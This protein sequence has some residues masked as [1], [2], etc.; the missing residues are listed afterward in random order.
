MVEVPCDDSS[1]MELCGES[2]AAISSLLD[3]D[4]LTEEEKNA[5]ILT[6]ADKQH[7]SPRLPY[8]FTIGGDRSKKKFSI[9]SR[10]ASNDAFAASRA[11]LPIYEYRANILD[12]INANQVVVISGETGSGKTTQVP[13]Y[14][15][16]Q[17][18]EE[19]K[20]C[21]I[22][23]T[24][25]RRLAATSIADRVSQERND[26]IGDSVGY[27]I[28]MDSCVSAHT[29]LIFTTSGYLLRCL[30]GSKAGEIFSS[31]THLLLDEVHER[32]K[33]TDFLLI[34]IK[35][36]LK[37]NPNVKIVLMSATLDSDVFSKYF[38]GCPVINVP[39]RCYDVDIIYLEDV[40]CMTEY[41][42]K[43][44]QVY[45][46]QNDGPK[47]LRQG[48]GNTSNGS[49]ALTNGDAPH[50]RGR[51]ADADASTS[52]AAAA[53]DA[54]FSPADIEF[55]DECLEQCLVAEDDVTF[56]QIY[57]LITDE[58]M[59]V[60]F[61][62]TFKSRSALS[63]AAE[64]GYI[65]VLASLLDLGA[66]AGL[67]DSNGITPLAHAM[68]NGHDECV[69]LLQ[70][71][72]DDDQIVVEATSAGIGPTGA[73]A[74]GEVKVASVEQTSI[75]EEYKTAMRK[76]VL[77]AYQ[78]TTPRPND[79][80]HDL[81]FHIISHVHS[82]QP[83][84]GSILV[85]LPG[86]DDIMKQK[87]YIESNLTETYS[88]QLFVLHS[89]L[90]AT[91]NSDQRRVFQR[92]PRGQ[93]KIILSTNI[94]ETSLTIDDV[95]YVIDSGRVKQQTY[96]SISDTTCLTSTW[97]SQA[98]AKQRAGRAG[99][100]RN[101][102][103]Y[104][105]YARDHYDTFE[106]YTLPEILRVPLTDIC[107]N[108]KILA[109]NISIEEFLL[110]ALQPPPVLSIRQS[111]NLLKKID[112]LDADENITYLGVHLADLPVDAQLGKCIIYGILLGCL[113]PIVTIVS[114][115]SVKDPFNLPMGDEGQRI[116]A[117]KKHFADDSLSDHIM[118][119]NTYN[120]WAKKK[121]LKSERQF[122]HDK[123]ISNGNM[124]MI[125]GVRKLIMGH[126][127]MVGIYS[128]DHNGRMPRALNANSEKTAVI[129]ACLT[130][131]FY[132]NVCRL[133]GRTNRIT[134][135]YDRKLLP[136]L[137]SVL[138]NR[139]STNQMD[140]ALQS[141]RA[142]FMIHGEKSRVSHYSLIRNVSLVAS[143][144]I[145]VFGGAINLPESNVWTLK[146]DS[147]NAEPEIGHFNP[148][149][150]SDE[151]DEAGDGYEKQE[152]TFLI[153]DWIQFKMDKNEANL[154]LQLRQKFNAV[155]A[156]FLKHPPMFTWSHS[157]S[158][159]LAALLKVIHIETRQQ[160]SDQEKEPNGDVPEEEAKTNGCALYSAAYSNALQPE[161]RRD[162]VG[163][164]RGANKKSNRNGGKKRKD[165]QKGKF[166]NDSKNEMHNAHGPVVATAMPSM[167][168]A[169]LDFVET[170]PQLHPPKGNDHSSNHFRSPATNLASSST[171]HP[172]NG[173]AASAAALSAA[174]MN[175]MQGLLNKS[176][177]MQTQAA[178]ASVSNGV[179]SYGRQP[180]TQMQRHLPCTKY[181]VLTIPNCSK[182]IETVFKSRW[183]FNKPISDI[184]EIE[185]LFP[186]ANIIIF[187]Y[188]QDKGAI[189]GAG[190]FNST[191][192][193]CS[194]NL[195]CQ[196]MHAG[197]AL[198]PVK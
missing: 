157:D 130:A 197:Y 144:N 114:A 97:I 142:E 76:F 196:T 137:S 41:K 106:K 109:D 159:T 69:Q 10:M 101:G 71:Y 158:R 9:P 61:M 62:H 42:T 31:V 172:Y 18:A 3:S 13:Q 125:H 165:K 51:R 120:E 177:A 181:Y 44:M 160:M 15:L 89:G 154:V 146:I 104:R 53:A 28:R 190:Q 108:A 151:E 7:N 107:L 119:L 8:S 27:Q 6:T 173:V 64:K 59:P 92:L 73:D 171:F 188:V 72:V 40:L 194:Y 102:H 24:Q 143:I 184:R 182:L 16:E 87:E 128:N 175:L 77:A 192:R 136:H 49:E 25:P 86:Y 155:V 48:S 134:A 132:P 174:Q 29:N 36:G 80:D 88:Y 68:R 180:T 45:M 95:V 170:K 116:Q 103:C 32:E 156:K 14:I 185:Y 37:L 4:P 55:F 23:C 131:G 63:I 67:V 93:R 163:F 30:M 169:P 148:N 141:T 164:A 133:D 26:R 54:R 166:K 198:K 83:T 167:A 187:F 115:L 70:S 75:E 121:Y 118:L 150:S 84:D 35:D 52:A 139:S 17:Y 122:C 50:A 110:K 66:N 57:Y 79:L 33:I 149:Q 39:G 56:D 186:K 193:N 34:A 78:M 123:M 94:A 191:N 129:M 19:K 85:F 12:A 161:H 183:M 168:E 1:K 47:E 176:A 126:L 127:Q 99:R 111:I 145:A 46:D 138:R 82:N 74:M 112:A 5:S 65:N 189:F 153:D 178:T 140:P 60:D 43:R 162:G 11:S 105:V 195:I 90:N 38:D 91:K 58:G 21:R 113:E 98:C 20:P 100:T 96:D 152:S 135:K 22:I 179:S 124:E 2:I 117:I 81:L 147:W